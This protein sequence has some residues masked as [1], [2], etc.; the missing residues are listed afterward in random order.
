MTVPDIV[1]R[2]RSDRGAGPEH[3]QDVKEAADEIDRLRQEVVILRWY[4]NKDCIDMTDEALKQKRETGTFP[5][6]VSFL[7]ED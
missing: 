6:E 4:G 7:F 3:W 1:A 2:L 5:Y